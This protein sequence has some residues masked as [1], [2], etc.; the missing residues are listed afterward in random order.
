MYIK[1]SCLQLTT[2][3]CGIL[4]SDS[5]VLAMHHTNRSTYRKPLRLASAEVTL[6]PADAW[7]YAFWKSLS[8][9][10]TRP[11]KCKSHVLF[12]ILAHSVNSTTKVVP[13][14]LFG[15]KSL[16]AEAHSC[17]RQSGVLALAR[18][19]CLSY[20]LC[21]VYSHLDHNSHQPRHENTVFIVISLCC[22]VGTWWQ[23]SSATLFSCEGVI[24]SIISTHVIA[25][26][27][28]VLQIIFMIC[29]TMLTRW[30]EC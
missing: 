13:S 4:C 9:V 23:V 22:V 11:K 24:S 6:I 27:E 1:T 3:P 20:Q 18:K 19:I 15:I 10:P 2:L 14:S 8:L 5:Y 30:A 12:S 16:Y 21:R 29:L 25:E 7:Y 28:L 17:E 26:V